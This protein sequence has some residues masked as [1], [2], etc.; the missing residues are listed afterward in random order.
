MIRVG[1]LTL[2]V[3]LPP[4]YPLGNLAISLGRWPVAPE[5]PYKMTIAIWNSFI[6]QQ[7]STGSAR[8]GVVFISKHANFFP[9]LMWQPKFPR[10][11]CSRLW[12]IGS[13]AAMPL[14]HQGP[15]SR[16]SEAMSGQ[17]GCRR[18][19]TVRYLEHYRPS[20]ATVGG[21]FIC[22]RCLC[23]CKRRSFWGQ[24]LSIENLIDSRT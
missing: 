19:F 23:P 4:R 17:S 14:P 13:A 11:E 18:H 1:G 21:V 9:E 7:S 8:D 15:W 20:S 16:S 22:S 3:T 5:T 2:Q 12:G 10:S 6:C 24:I